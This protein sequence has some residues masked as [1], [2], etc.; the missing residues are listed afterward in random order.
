[1]NGRCGMMVVERYVVHTLII[2]SLNLEPPVLSI[3]ND[4]FTG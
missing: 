3:C 4:G 2:K 1:M